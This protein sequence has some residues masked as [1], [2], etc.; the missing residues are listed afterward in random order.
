LP[1]AG[2]AVLA[3]QAVGGLGVDEA[4]GVHKGDDVEV[5]LVEDGLD[6]RVGAVVHEQLVREV[7]DD[8]GRDP[9]ASVHAAVEVD[10]GLGSLAAAAPE[11]DAEE[12]APLH[13]LADVEDLRVGREGGLEVVEEGDVVGVGVVRVEPRQAGDGAG[14]GRCFGQ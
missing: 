12:V 13:R 5:V 14:S 6:R 10:G 7:L 4:V 11:V 8:L 9:L 1:G 2:L 3:P